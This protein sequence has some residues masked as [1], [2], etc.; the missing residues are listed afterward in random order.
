MVLDWL[1]YQM[2]KFYSVLKLWA[3]DL[4]MKEFLTS[5]GGSYVKK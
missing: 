3:R 4:E 2:G 1:N 5:F